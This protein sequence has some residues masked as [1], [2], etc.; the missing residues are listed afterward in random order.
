MKRFDAPC[1]EI[2]SIIYLPVCL[3]FVRPA[4]EIVAPCPEE[5]SF[6]LLFDSLLEDL[7]NGLAPIV[8]RYAHLIRVFLVPARSK[9]EPV[10]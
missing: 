5:G 7:P 4:L 1:K 9:N 3:P 6:T 8:L 10:I 2:Y